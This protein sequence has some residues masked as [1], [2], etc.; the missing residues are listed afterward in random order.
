MAQWLI[1]FLKQLESIVPPLPNGHHGIHYAQYGSDS[2]GWTDKLALS[3]YWHG[4][5]QTF[6]L[7]EDDV[8]GTPDA[9]VAVIVA[10]LAKIEPQ[11]SLI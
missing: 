9:A 7:E 3:I 2:V 11:G 1:S 5:F 10:E 6:F 8:L 4:T